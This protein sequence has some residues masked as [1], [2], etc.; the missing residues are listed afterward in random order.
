MGQENTTKNAEELKILAHHITFQMA[1]LRLSL[2]ALTKNAD[3]ELSTLRKVINQEANFSPKF[4]FIANLAK[5][6]KCSPI[7]LLIDQHLP[8]YI[9][10]VNLQSVDSFIKESETN[11]VKKYP[12]LK[13]NGLFNCETFAV[14][15]EYEMFGENHTVYFCC[16]PQNTLKANALHIIIINSII[17]LARILSIKEHSIEYSL[18]NNMTYSISLNAIKVLAIVSRLIPY[19]QEKST[20]QL[21][22]A[23]LKFLE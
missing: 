20:T 10:V 14:K 22:Q 16:R 2:D 11:N 17:M 19:H 7:D 21:E 4:N 23:H 13:V 15:S 9:P 12:M 1:E 8:Y 3:V 5:F 18:I 6:F